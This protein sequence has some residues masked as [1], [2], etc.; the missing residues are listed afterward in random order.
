MKPI[1]LAKSL[2]FLLVCTLF[3]ACATQGNNIVKLQ[4]DN[5]QLL[6]ENNHLKQKIESI[7]KRNVGNGSYYKSEKNQRFIDSVVCSKPVD[8]SNSQ[9]L[10][11]IEVGM[12]EEKLLEILGEPVKSTETTKMNTTKGLL[13]GRY[14]VLIKHGIVDCV[15]DQKGYKGKSLFN[16]DI[17]G[18]ASCEEHIKTYPQYVLM[19][20]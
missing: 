12:I 17:N 15:V 6:K 20:R 5:V 10:T 14:W 2:F 8:E 11:K 7:E 4:Q 13:Y 16:I 19:Q 18:I 9:V 1:L 3:S